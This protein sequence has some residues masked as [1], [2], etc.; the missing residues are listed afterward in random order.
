MTDMNIPNMTD[1]NILNMTD[2]NTRDDHLE[3]YGQSL[4][5]SKYWK[6]GM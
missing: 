4:A 3:S 5:P 1:M 6:S 2:M